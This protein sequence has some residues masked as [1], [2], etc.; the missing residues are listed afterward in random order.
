MGNRWEPASDELRESWPVGAKFFW[1]LS[2]LYSIDGWIIHLDFSRNQTFGSKVYRSSEF[3]ST[4]HQL[5]S[6]LESGLI[7]L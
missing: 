1:N 2:V 5:W 4:L 3:G 7:G 6:A